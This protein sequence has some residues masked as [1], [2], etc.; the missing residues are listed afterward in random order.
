MVQYLFLILSLF[1]G[2]LLLSQKK[3]FESQLKLEQLKF[4]QRE[5]EFQALREQFVIL[6]S[7]K[8]KVQPPQLENQNLAQAKVMVK[9]AEVTEMMKYR[10]LELQQE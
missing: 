8:V 7:E 10:E 6:Q 4:Q 2:L 3:Q 1:L 5:S 9:L